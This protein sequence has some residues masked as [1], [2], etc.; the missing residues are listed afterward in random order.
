MPID[1]LGHF[2]E[3]WMDYRCACLCVLL[4]TLRNKKNAKE[5]L[6]ETKKITGRLYLASLRLIKR[7]RVKQQKSGRRTK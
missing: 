3:H 4:E 2:G 1:L 7:E 5:T 6:E